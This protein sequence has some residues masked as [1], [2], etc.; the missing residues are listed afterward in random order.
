MRDLQE[1]A[2]SD[3]RNASTTAPRLPQ[4]RCLRAAGGAGRPRMSARRCETRPGELRP[5][6]RG[7]QRTRG[8]HLTGRDEHL[9]LLM[10][11]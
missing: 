3:G 10:R 6:A 7:T 9:Q 5:A 4:R 11:G 8:Q 2:S 1:G